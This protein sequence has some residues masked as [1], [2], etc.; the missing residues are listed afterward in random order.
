MATGSADPARPVAGWRR[1][2]RLRLVLGALLWIGLGLALCGGALYAVMRAHLLAEIEEELGHHGG[3]LAA[4]VV[5][6]P[7]GMLGLRTEMSDHRFATPGSGYYWQVEGAAQALRSPSLGAFRLSA[8]PADA[9][10]QGTGPTGAVRQLDRTVMPSGGATPV[11]ISVAID[12]DQVAVLLRGFARSLALSLALVAAGLMAAVVAQVTYG[13][14][15]LA[16]IRAGLAAIRRG[17]QDRLPDDLPL[18]VQPLAS[19]LNDMIRA[20]DEV[21]QRACTQAGNLAHA[22]KTPLA[23]LIDEAH[24]LQAAG[25]DGSVVLREAE[26]MRRQIDYQLAQARAAASRGRPRTATAVVPA[27]QGIVAAVSRM[28]RER[29]L[30]FALEA[31]GADAAAAV[32]A[33][34]LDEMLGNVI[35]NAAKFARHRVAVAVEVA[36]DRLRVRVDDD[37]PGMPEAAREA[38]FRVGQRLDEAVPGH[39]LG[40]AIVRDI[41]ALYGGRAAIETSPLGGAR[42]ILELPRAE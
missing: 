42:L 10:H 3:E 26:R 30:E 8:G 12:E 32:E 36:G 9:L 37:G 41:A 24:R 35:E 39:G 40:L 25:H 14:R 20:N 6:G 21:V 34:D 13:L 28:Y 16:R 15:P 31:A 5:Q 27:V 22:L 2:F 29:E 1:S 18:E 38:V 4:M 17:E 7:G 33:E 23:I 11:R 19:S